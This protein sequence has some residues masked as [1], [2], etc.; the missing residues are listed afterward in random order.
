MLLLSIRRLL[1]S[2]SGLA[3]L[4]LLLLLLGL[5]LSE[6]VLVLSSSGHLS[7]ELGPILI[8]TLDRERIRIHE[9]IEA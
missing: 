1:E 9:R 6:E 8:R 5:L 3:L 2:T 7:P 4:L